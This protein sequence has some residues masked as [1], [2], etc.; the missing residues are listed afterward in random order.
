MTK[1]K[2]AR[3]KKPAA[4]PR[5]ALELPTAKEEQFAQRFLIHFNATRA[6]HEA[7]YSERTA[8][9]IGYALLRRPRVQALIEEGRRRLIARNELSQDLVVRMAMELADSD[10]TEVTGWDE[11]GEGT[12]VPSYAMPGRVRRAIRSVKR[13]TRRIFTEAGEMIEDVEVEFKLH[14]KDNAQRLLAQIGGYVKH[15][16]EH[17]HNHTGAIEHR[18]ALKQLTDEE[19]AQRRRAALGQAIDPKG[20]LPPAQA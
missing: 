18:H 20:A 16:H 17:E 6:A 12:Y 13:K 4:R 11:N 1:R 19:L 2:T 14:G 8:K 7:G 15:K 9:Q 5:N 3:K 10:I